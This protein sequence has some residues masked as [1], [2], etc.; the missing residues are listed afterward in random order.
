MSRYLQVYCGEIRFLVDALRVLEVVDHPLAD[1]AER[2]RLLSAAC[3]WRD[4]SVTCI[5]MPLFFGQRD[6]WPQRGIVVDSGIDDAALRYLMLA[7]E[8]GEHLLALDDGE[9]LPVVAEHSVLADVFDG[10]LVH[11]SLQPCPLV[12]KFPVGWATQLVAGSAEGAACR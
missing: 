10:V 1:V 9:T 4:Q 7:V 8:G 6:V 11:D 12:L 2:E 5:D 3:T